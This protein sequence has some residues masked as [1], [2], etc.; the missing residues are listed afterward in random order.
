MK[1]S[2]ET[3][4]IELKR[5]LGLWSAVAIVVG[6]VI[7]SGI[8]LVPRTMIQRVGSPEMVFVVWVVGGLLSLAGALSYAELAAAMPEAGGEYVYLREAYGPVWGFLYSWTQMWVAKSGSIATLATGFFYYLTNFLPQLN[9]ILLVVPL[10]IGAHGAPLEIRY[11]QIFAMALILFLAGVN[12]FGVK[13]GGEVQVAV[14]VVKVALIL[15]IIVAG[16]G[17]G[18][19]PAE[20]VSHATAVPLTF[21][22]FFAAMVAALWAYDGWNNVSMVASEIRK[23]QRNLPLALIWGT[24][25]VVIIYLLANAAYFHV[26][27]PGEVAASNRVAADMMRRI[28][29][30]AGANMVSV[31]AMISIFAALNGSILSGA[32]VPYA[33]ARD[34]YFFRAIARVHPQFHTPGVSILGLSAWAALLV[35]SGTYDQLFTYVIFASWLLYGMTTAAVLVLRKKRP[36]LARPYST[37]GYPVVPV[38]FVAIALCLVISTLFDSPRESLLGLAFIFA[39]LPFYFHWRKQRRQN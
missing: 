12:Y 21:A 28:L 8:F 5:D 29:G 38:L 36:D 22:G 33:A 2:T 26:L 17:W 14:T 15:F 16:L 27:A 11:G 19:R 13:V 7:G 24:L 18:H 9:G 35:L 30:G 34:G 31:A 20:V 32:R 10:P 25:A 39:G 37:L 23:P 3:A 4:P 6:T 1:S